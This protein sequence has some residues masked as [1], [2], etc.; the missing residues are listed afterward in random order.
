MSEAA[1]LDRLVARLKAILVL[2]SLNSVVV[3]VRA[4]LDSVL[5]E[6]ASL[7]GV[8]LVLL[9]RARL[10]SGG[11]GGRFRDVAALALVLAVLVDPPATLEP[12]RLDVGLSGAGNLEC[13]RRVCKKMDGVGTGMMREILIETEG[14]Q[15]VHG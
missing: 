3:L 8:I 9:V 15:D 14:G 2:T 1:H 11:P 12:A 7:D 13:A 10:P 6:V 5:L 4:R